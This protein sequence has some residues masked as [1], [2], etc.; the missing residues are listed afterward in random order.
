MR[1]LDQVATDVALKMGMLDMDDYAPSPF[2]K[3]LVRAGMVEALEDVRRAIE[4][5]MRFPYNAKD[6]RILAKVAERLRKLK[7]DEE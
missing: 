1:E 2:D 7:K 3:A 5:E 4:M 6:S